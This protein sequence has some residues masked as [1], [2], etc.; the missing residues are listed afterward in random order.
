MD[1]ARRLGMLDRTVAYPVGNGFEVEY[2]LSRR[3]NQWDAIDLEL[4][5]SAFVAAIA[6]VAARLPKPV[7]LIDC[8][9]DIG[10]FVLKVLAKCPDIAGVTAFEPNHMGWRYLSANLNRLGIPADPRNEGVGDFT[11]RGA[12]VRSPDDNDDHACFVKQ[13]TDGGDFN[14]VRVDD[15]GILPNRSIVLKIDT[16]GAELSV[17]RGASETLKRAPA[18]AVGFEAHRRVAERTRIDPSEIV[19]AVCA[20]R[21]CRVFVAER[22]GLRLDASKPFA[23]QVGSN[24]WVVNVVCV[25][26]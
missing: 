20:L 2:P 24:W 25:S 15:L 17:V 22:P 10:L 4:Y 1:M 13:V 9:A 14:V 12:L 7:H 5:E 23:D 18:F 21:P 6:D 3:C 16:E 26:E 19:A 8:G 11:G